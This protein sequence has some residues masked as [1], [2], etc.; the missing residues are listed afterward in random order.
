MRRSIAPLWWQHRGCVDT[1]RR[2]LYA[3]S[4]E[5]QFSPEMMAKLNRVAAEAGHATD[6]YVRD[7]VERY[8]DEDARFRAAVRKG[9]EQIDR[10]QFL[11][12]EEMDARVDRML[13][14]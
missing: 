8:V 11:E 12:E 7:L 6:T 9:F 1:V 3:W 4:V 13:R 14:G 5:V 2:Q 10:G